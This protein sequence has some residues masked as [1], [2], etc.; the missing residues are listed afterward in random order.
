MARWKNINGVLQ[1]I[2]GSVR[3]DQV[4]NKLSRNAISNKAVS[5]KFETVDG[6]LGTHQDA[7]DE[8]STN[9][10][11]KV[12]KQDIVNNLTTTAEGYALDARQGKALNGTLKT[13]A[14]LGYTLAGYKVGTAAQSI[15]SNWQ[16]L[17]ICVAYSSTI[18]QCVV[19]KG[20]YGAF[21]MGAN[22]SGW[23]GGVVTV[24]ATSVSMNSMWHS[25]S[26]VTGSSTMYVYYK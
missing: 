23:V 15:P 16:E 25:G 12:S 11:G 18:V 2:A 10:A 22:I 4:L 20:I 6:T 13:K 3:I 8:I 26:A 1:K 7:I 21:Y 5:E 9:L 14:P 17:L 19:P 24:S